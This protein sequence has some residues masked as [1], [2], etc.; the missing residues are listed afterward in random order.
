MLDE[1]VLTSRQNIKQFIR[2]GKQAHVQPEQTNQPSPQE[3]YS[4]ANHAV[5]DRF[6]YSIASDPNANNDNINHHHHKTDKYSEIAQ[7][8]VEEESKER[9][10][11]Q[12]S[13]NME[14]YDL[15]EK[16]GEGAFSVVHKAQDKTTGQHVAIKIIRKYQLDA[17][18]QASVL[19]E[20][21]IMRQLRHQNIV[22]FI[23]F[24]ESEDYYLIVQELVS[25]GELFAEIVKYTYF[26]EDLVRH[27][28]IQVAQAIRYLHEVVGVVHRDIKPENLLFE[29]IPFT[30]SKQVKFRKS[31]DP[32]SKRDEGEF[33]YGLGGGGIGVVKLADFG[34]S[35]QIWE[36]N[37]KTPCGTVG[38][39]APE[40]VRDERYSKEVDM[41]AIGC[42]VYTLLCGFPPFY[43]E[44][45]DVLTEK[46]ARG[47]FS[48][49]QPWWDEI[50]NGAKNCVSKL[51]TVNPKQRYTI[52]EFLEDPWIVEHIQ[53]SQQAQLQ[54]LTLNPPI[55]PSSTTKPA[56]GIS[57]PSTKHPIQSLNKNLDLVGFDTEMYSPA[58][59]ALRDAFDISTAVHRIG[60]EAALG[61]TYAQRGQ[62][63]SLKEDEELHS[64]ES[65]DTPP[66]PVKQTI[67][68]SDNQLF[69]LSLAGAS[70]LERRKN[71]RK[72]VPVI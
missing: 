33:V 10:K 61:K 48:F 46:V 66:K 40:I 1:H 70:I 63:E 21:T 6:D 42:V 71:K 49:L 28:I 51:L 53:K 54:R 56:A 65:M 30:P 23:D 45:I 37:T 13:M 59:V 19:K 3:S 34:L 62:M 38:Y 12:Q 55:L 41:W 2:H 22:E 39:T 8:L 27:I 52:D 36:F 67:P 57:K 35:K 58:A 44:R 17:Q 31:D 60:E 14:R 69:D 72:T 24:I 15:L 29:P 47:Q 7:G 16:M 5:E 18:Q 25:G 9:Q 26:S 68:A 4:M 64:P 11:K 50:S 32:S 43:D 20:V